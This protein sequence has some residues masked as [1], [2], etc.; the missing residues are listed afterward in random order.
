ME[1]DVMKF[2][3]IL[4]VVLGHITK[5][6]FPDGLIP[7]DENPK[8]LIFISCFMDFILSR[9]LLKYFVYSFLYICRVVSF[10]NDM[11]LGV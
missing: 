10:D 1:L 2:W 6:Y 5:M 9:F 11:F 7:M 8:A 3:G 4:F